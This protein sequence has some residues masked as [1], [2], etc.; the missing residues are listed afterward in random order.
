MAAE[1]VPS[2][3]PESQ[4][5]LAREF[6]EH[7]MAGDWEVQAGPSILDVLD[8]MACAGLVFARGDECAEAYYKLISE[9]ASV[10]GS[11]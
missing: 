5:E 2:A 3:A 4:E 6:R 9:A 8:I 11:K 1:V 7:L 10:S